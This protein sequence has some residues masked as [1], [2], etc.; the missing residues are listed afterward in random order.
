MAHTCDPSNLGGSGKRV[1][2]F[3]PCLGKFS[4]TLSK[5][6]KDLR[7]GWGYNSMQRAKAMGLISS[8]S[9]KKKRKNQRVITSVTLN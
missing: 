3:E 4:E 7:R 9:K 5:I 2:M 6:T 8:T 1:K